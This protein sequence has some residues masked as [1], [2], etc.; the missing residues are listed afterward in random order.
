MVLSAAGEGFSLVAGSTP[1][2]PMQPQQTRKVRVERAF[3]VSG[4]P[5]KVG[6][7]VELPRVLALEMV[8]AK[9]ATFV[10]EA[11]ADKAPAGNQAAD[12]KGKTDARK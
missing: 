11:P 1:G 3:Y 12:A 7:V 2:E 9:K 6:D 4:T 8:A 10:S 5:T